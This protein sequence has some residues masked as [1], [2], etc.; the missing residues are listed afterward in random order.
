MNERIA[1]A[2]EKVSERLGAVEKT[3][4]AQTHAINSLAAGLGRTDAR[5]T[6]NETRIKPVEEHIQGTKSVRG[7]LLTGAG[8]TAT[9]LTIVYTALRL[10][11]AIK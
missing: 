6:A 4:I 11:G 8:V 10:S 3:Q 1:T 7:A 5:V 9:L 2:L